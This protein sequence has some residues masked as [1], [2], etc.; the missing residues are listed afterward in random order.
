MLFEIVSEQ[1]CWFAVLFLSVFTGEWAK[2][3]A[4]LYDPALQRLATVDLP[5]L[6]ASSKADSTTR[7]Y[8]TYWKKWEVWVSSHPS[9]QVFPVAPFHL[10]LYLAHLAS[11]GPKSVAD[12]TIAAIKWVHSLAGFPSPTDDPM[13][14]TALQGF[15]RLHSSPTSRKLPITPHILR[16]IWKVHGQPNASLA[17]LRILFIS[18]ISYAGFLRFD[19]LKKVSRN[20]CTFS[21]DCLSIHLPSSKSDQFRQGSDIVIARS[22][23]DTCPVRVAERYFA[24]L[25]DPSDCSLPV[26]RRLQVS[27][28]G[29]IPTSYPLSYSRTREIVLDAIKPFVPDISKYGLHSMRSGGASAAFNAQ[30]P[31]FLISRQGRWSSD[32]ARNKYL[33]IDSKSKLLASTSLGI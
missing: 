10:S 18:F 13:V 27:K 26:L 11:T 16:E 31:P 24:A 9:I 1:N 8:L 7:L 29:L 19:D 33:Q 23:K 17:D 12:P 25:G 28:R 15:K 3:S 14:K 20:S 32:K 2:L 30:V 21:Q 5:A 6:L 4:P 22:G